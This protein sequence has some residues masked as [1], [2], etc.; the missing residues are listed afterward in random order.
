[1]CKV[2]NA[3]ELV[4]IVRRA[5]SVYPP[6]I[7]DQDTYKA[8]LDDIAVVVTDYFG[9]IPHGFSLMQDE[10][11]ACVCCNNSVPEDGGIWAEYD[12]D[13][14]VEEF[15]GDQTGAEDAT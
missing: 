10:W 9:G 7:D 14:S 11:D 2:I 6:L 13:I 15:R 12:T 4:D 8:F 5:V 1:M 3:D